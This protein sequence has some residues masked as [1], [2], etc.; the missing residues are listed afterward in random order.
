M[1][2]TGTSVEG[3]HAVIVYRSLN[4]LKRL[5]GKSVLLG[6]EMLCLVATQLPAA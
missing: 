6:L 4:S 5:Y 1:N 2:N 3:L